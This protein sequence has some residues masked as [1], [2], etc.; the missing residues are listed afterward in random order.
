MTVSRSRICFLMLFCLSW[1][2]LS[3]RS[4]G[5]GEEAIQL[6]YLLF[7]VFIILLVI[8][9]FELR[10][11]AL[12]KNNRVLREKEIAAKEVL[13]QRNLLSRRNR[14]IEDSLKY[15]HRIQQAM[16]TT[17]KEIRSLFAESFVLQRPKDIVSGD[18]FWAKEINGVIFFSVVDCT[19]HG[20]PGAFMSLIGL[21]LFRHIIIEQGIHKPS[22]ILTEMNLYF[23]K[24]FGKTG[25]LTL[26]DGM[27][28][29][30]CTF[31]KKDMRLEFAGAFHSLYILRNSEI[32]EVKGNN[33]I[34][35]P[36]YGFDRQAFT[37][38]VINLEQDDIIYLF[39]DGYVD[40]FG[41]PEGK[42]FKYR[43]FRHLLL[44]IHDQ[45][46]EKQKE[47]LE[48]NIMKWMGSYEQIDDI[49]I[50]GIK[51]ASCSSSL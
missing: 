32:L 8:L 36:D 29:S 45:S 40:Q 5:E 21:E 6:F 31:Y 14:N 49:L 50:M 44:A 18:F 19:G 3:G 11:R 41:G 4:N 23:E 37:N 25:D 38:Q 10:T 12:R 24:I 39:S 26:K 51:P 28:L 46:M 33:S 48:V 27:D 22:D 2:P 9:T 17:E 42:K 16:F 43:R 20:V 30:F 35:G 47:Q 13:E 1:I 7:G 15:A 34:V